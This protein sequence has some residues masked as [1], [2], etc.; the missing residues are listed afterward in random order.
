M[1]TAATARRL[2]VLIVDDNRHNANMLAELIRQKG[3]NAR[4]AY[5][6]QQ[7][8]VIVRVWPPDVAILDVAMDGIGG[9]E[10]AKRMRNEVAGPIMLVAVTGVGA[11]DEVARMNAGAFDHRFLKPVDP[12][13]MIRLLD[14]RAHQ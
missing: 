10:L 11:N 1:T 7:A 4:V 5:G 14:A 8:L 9:A 2:S 12:D 13:E 6:G 3:H